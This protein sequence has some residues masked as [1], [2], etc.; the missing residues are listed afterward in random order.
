MNCS[1]ILSHDGLKPVTGFTRVN[2][3]ICA[4][5]LFSARYTSKIHIHCAFRLINDGADF[6]SSEI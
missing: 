3:P 6:E 4:K 1:A 5:M 2:P